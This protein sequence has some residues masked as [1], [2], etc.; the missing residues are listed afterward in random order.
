MEK[1]AV[2]SHESIA[3]RMAL[4]KFYWKKTPQI[5]MEIMP[6]FSKIDIYLRKTVWKAQK[7]VSRKE[8]FRHITAIK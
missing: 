4:R 8:K 1:I 3:G 6:G 5:I 7:H 2:V